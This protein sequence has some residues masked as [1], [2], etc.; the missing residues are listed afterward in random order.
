[1]LVAAWHLSGMLL[2]FGEELTFQVSFAVARQ[3]WDLEST[4]QMPWWKQQVW[5][6]VQ[7]LHTANYSVK[8][9]I[10]AAVASPWNQSDQHSRRHVSGSLTSH[11]VLQLS[12]WFYKL[13]LTITFSAKLARLSFCHLHLKTL[14]SIPLQPMK[15]RGLQTFFST[16]R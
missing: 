6:L 14:K 7:K 12:Q 5:F 13:F 8:V 2:M 9:M 10:M 15:N 3:T 16:F 1:M 11:L 4:N